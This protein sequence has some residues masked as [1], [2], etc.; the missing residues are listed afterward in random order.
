MDFVASLDNCAAYKSIIAQT[1]PV[2]EVP[3]S[4]GL[5]GRLITAAASLSLYKLSEFDDDYPQRFPKRVLREI[6][7]HN[8]HLG[9]IA[10]ELMAIKDA[11]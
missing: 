11:L 2:A 8:D 6:E 4:A 7:K 9:G 1:A 3:C 10:R 5:K